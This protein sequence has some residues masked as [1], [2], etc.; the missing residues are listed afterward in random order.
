[1]AIQPLQEFC[2]PL[3]NEPLATW[4]KAISPQ[5]HERLRPESQRNF[6]AWLAALDA[7]PEYQQPQVR[8]DTDTITTISKNR[9][10][11]RQIAEALQSLKPWRKGPFC[12]NDVHIDTE[13][14][15][16]WKWNRLSPHIDLNGLNVLDVGCGNGY[17]SLRMVGAGAKSVVGLD[18]SLLYW[19]QFQAITHFTK[20]NRATVLPLSVECLVDN[21]CTFDAVFSMGVLYHRRQPL[22]HL[23]LLH[24]NLVK[25][26]QLILETLI[27]HGHRS[28]QLVPPERYANMRNVW[29]LPTLPLLFDQLQLA[30]FQQIR[31]VDVNR[32][33]VS[34]QRSTDWMTFN[35]LADALDENDPT[36]TREGHS[37]PLRAILIAEK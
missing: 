22:E 2:R 19:A 5:V 13:W 34:E 12:F 35:S 25:G 23:Q 31:C 1:M 26:G 27:L 6:P 18:T 24:Q 14:R 37:S 4:I 33:T 11:D 7:L 20:E 15:S 3:D 10:F 17:Y 21:P 16:D 9:Q 32:T 8:L 36:L 28:E 30:G 29:S